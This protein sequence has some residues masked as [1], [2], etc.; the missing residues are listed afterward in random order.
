[1]DASILVPAPDA[2]PVPWG[3]FKFFLILTFMLHILFMNIMVGGGFIAFFNYLKRDSGISTDSLERDMSRKLTFIIAF[4]VN[5][6]VAPLLFLQV[7]Y[8]HFMYVSSLL[9][10]VWWLSVVGLLIIAYY[11]AYFYKFKFDAKAGGTRGYFIG[12][13]VLIL[14]FVGFLFTNNMSMM[15]TPASWVSYFQNPHGTLLNLSEPSLF[16]RFLH[17]MTA[18]VAIGGLFIAIIWSLKQKKG[19][20]FAKENAD[21]GMKWFT[22]ATMI[23]IVIGFWFLVSLPGDIMQ[24]FMGKSVI[25]TTIFLISLALTA[26]TLVFGIY[27]KVRASVVSVLVLVFSMIMMRDMVRTA[28][29]K[30]FFE[31]SELNV[32]PDYS[33]LILFLVSLAAGISVVIYVIRLAIKSEQKTSLSNS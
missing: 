16:P 15:L 13:T 25:H 14:L 9:M 18:S 33:P 5:F 10:G 3:W 24:L 7:L 31:V 23:Q 17:F 22:S 27:R 1:M 28:Y 8:G 2:I 32:I 19:V 20:A 21:Q 4:T 12:A 30:P 11:S 26:L 29:L 6:G